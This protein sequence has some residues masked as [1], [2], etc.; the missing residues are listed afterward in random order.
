MLWKPAA[1]ALELSLVPPSSSGGGGGSGAVDYSTRAPDLTIA[2]PSLC[3]ALFEV[4]LGSSSVVPDARGAWVSGAKALLDSE[5]VK[6][7]TRRSD[8]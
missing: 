1:G 8:V 6:R 2:S 5:N 4:Y 7:E 3:R